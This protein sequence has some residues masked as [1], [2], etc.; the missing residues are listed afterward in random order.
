MQRRDSI[1]VTLD[2]DVQSDI[3][4]VI[5]HERGGNPYRVW[6]ISRRLASRYANPSVELLEYFE[7]EFLGALEKQEEANDTKAESSENPFQ[8]VTP[9]PLMADKDAGITSFQIASDLY[10]KGRDLEQQGQIREALATYQSL[11]EITPGFR[12]I[13]ERMRTLDASL[14]QKPVSNIETE[15]DRG[16]AALNVKNWGEA[17]GAFTKVVNMNPDYRDATDKLLEANRAWVEN[18]DVDQPVNNDLKENNELEELYS[19]GVR[20]IQE[21]DFSQAFAVLRQAIQIAPDYKNTEVLYRHA[22]DMIRLQSSEPV[23]SQATA[24]KEIMLDSLYRAGFRHKFNGN[25]VEALVAFSKIQNIEPNFRDVITE[26]ADLGDIIE[27]ESRASNGLNSPASHDEYNM[28]KTSSAS[29]IM[30]GLAAAAVLLPTLG[31]LFLYPSNRARIALMTGNRERA[32]LIY[33]SMLDK[34]PHK[35]KLYSNIASIYLT[36]NRSDEKAIQVYQKVIDLRLAAKN[37]YGKLFA[38]LRG[39]NN[40]QITGPSIRDDY[41]GGRA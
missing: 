2:E 28:V 7:P 21:E 35:L 3:Y 16:V 32:C 15:Y 12:D 20:A 39:Y 38:I 34:Y 5:K 26:I 11:A 24:Q 36:S 4:G 30:I 33:E 13:Q 37:D 31:I 23:L 14:S 10:Q 29:K 22:I 19:E 8:D 6:T 1:V 17:L 41:D 18:P 40:R 25:P 27:K 9:G